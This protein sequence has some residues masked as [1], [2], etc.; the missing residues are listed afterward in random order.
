MKE[1]LLHISFLHPYNFSLCPTDNTDFRILPPLQQSSQQSIAFHLYWAWGLW[2]YF[3]LK[4]CDLEACLLFQSNVIWP[5][6]IHYPY[7][8]AFPDVDS[9]TRGKKKSK[10]LR[11]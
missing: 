7:L 11:N 4:K 3:Q 2:Y 5:K 8:Q 10:V 6:K 1:A 9:D